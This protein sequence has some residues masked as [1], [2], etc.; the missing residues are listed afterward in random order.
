MSRNRKAV[1][2]LCVTLAVLETQRRAMHRARP[3]ILSPSRLFMNPYMHFLAMHDA[4]R[5]GC[6]YDGT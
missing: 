5:V 6:G 2:G 1:R 3:E 4:A